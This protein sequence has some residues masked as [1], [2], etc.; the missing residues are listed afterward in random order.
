MR[1]NQKDCQKTIDLFLFSEDEN[2]HYSLIKKDF[3]S[4][5]HCHIC[6][7]KFFRDKE[8]NQIHKVRDH[9]HFTGEY[10]DA[11]H[12]E[13][14]LECKKPLILPAIFHNLRGYD[15]HLFIKQLAKVSGDLSC[16]PSTEEKYISFSKKIVVDHYY[17]R[18]MG[19]LLPKKF[20]IRF[21]DSFK[22]L[23]TSLNDLVENLEPSDFKN[24][25]RVIKNN[26]SLLPRK[27]VYP[28]DYVTSIGK[29]KET[30]FSYLKLILII[31]SHYGIHRMII[32]L[33][34]K[35]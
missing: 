4:A 2:Q 35:K 25:N 24:L 16:I 21:I 19:K 23:S 30:R 13:C 20:D 5:I 18:K 34:Q 10:R 11:A 3:Q 1:I 6:E 26:S 12:N 29:L 17:S 15:S 32:L 31:L 8:T 27:G 28:Y 7:Q 14:N 33:P 9:C 22:F